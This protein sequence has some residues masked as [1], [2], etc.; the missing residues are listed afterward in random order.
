MSSDRGSRR[1]GDQPSFAFSIEI[2][3][4]PAKFDADTASF[5]PPQFRERTS[6]RRD[7]RPRNRIALGET[8]QHADTP[9]P[10]WL[11][12][13][14][15]SGDAAALPSSVMNWRRFHS[16]TSS[17]VASSVGGTVRP[18]ALAVLRLITSSIPR[19]GLYR[20]VCGLLTLKDTIDISSCATVLVDNIGAVGHQTAA[21]DEKALEINRGQSMLGRERDDQV[22]MNHRQ[23]A[24]RYD[25]ATIRR[26][27]KGGNVALDVGC[28]AHVDRDDLDAERR[29][30]GLDGGE[31]TDPCTYRGITRT[32]AR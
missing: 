15:A 25:Q 11:L 20:E 29:C 26:T 17:A 2:R 6:E 3:A 5:R 7:H 10:I 28:V 16:I 14:P 4:G 24:S 18:S 31:L 19:W 32:A 8:H 13:A 1:A 9:Y 23:R 12:R 21:H 27:S 22:A 30:H